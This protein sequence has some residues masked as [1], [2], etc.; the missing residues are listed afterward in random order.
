[1]SQP[2]PFIPSLEAIEHQD[3]AFFKELAAAFRPMCLNKLQ[4]SDIEFHSDSLTK[5]Q[6][7]LK[8]RTNIQIN[9]KI[10]PTSTPNAWVFP[11][12]L[13]KNHSMYQ[14]WLKDWLTNEDG[15]KAIKAA[16]DK[17]ARASLDRKKVWVTGFFSAMTYEVCVT[18][19]ILNMC[20]GE[21]VA[22]IFLHEIG[23]LWSYFEF[24][25]LT[26]KTNAALRTVRKEFLQCEDSEQKVA[27]V[28]SVNSTYGFSQAEIDRLRKEL[29]VENVEIA[30]LNSMV[31]E[32]YS[33]L[34]FS[35]YDQR[36]WE[37]SSDQ[38]STRM[39]GGAYVVSGLDKMHREFGD[40]AYLSLF[41]HTVNM[42]IK[43]VLSIYLSVATVGLFPLI[44]MLMGDPF[45]EGE[46]YD[47]PGER[48][49]RVRHEMI[50]A[51]RNPSVS[52]EMAQRMIEDIRGIDATLKD[53][54]DRHGARYYFWAAISPGARRRRNQV[55]VEQALERLANNDLYI[56]AADL[57]HR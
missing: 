50:A 19:G 51:L 8:A 45:C 35:L 15:A 48:F 32:S 7:L 3:Q 23:H 4:V 38:F 30:V 28:S 16:N 2:N 20:S 40:P 11:P 31:R 6:R 55:K 21:E 14:D 42:S 39:G 29:S 24:L 52:K 47:R 57:K 27:L 13:S 22:A 10:E 49:T 56:A 53:I 17:K 25:T 37:F 18:R 5:I 26:A 36:A 12:M 33:E 41:A 34:G 9:L 43:V 54:V 46:T 1:M 44:L